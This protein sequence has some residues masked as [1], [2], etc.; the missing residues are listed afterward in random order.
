MVEIV[1]RYGRGRESSCFVSDRIFLKILG[2]MEEAPD[3][4][5]TLEDVQREHMRRVLG[6]TSDMARAAKTL[7][8]SRKTL[9]ERRKK[10]G[11]DIIKD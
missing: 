11:L 7:G 5:A 6:T 4:G 10:Y 2:A 3:V 8:I 9:W 1:F